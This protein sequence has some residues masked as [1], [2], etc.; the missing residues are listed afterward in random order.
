MKR[1]RDEDAS[2]LQ[3]NHTVV[4]EVKTAVVRRDRHTPRPAP[5][6]VGREI[7]VV[8]AG[9]QAVGVDVLDRLADNAQKPPVLQT[10]EIRPG[11]LLELVKRL[12]GPPAVGAQVV[13]ALDAAQ[14]AAVPMGDQPRPA[15]PLAFWRDIGAVGGGPSDKCRQNARKKDKILDHSILLL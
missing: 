6:L 14:D 8:V 4:H 9:L 5:A 12:P 11:A 15:R 7:G 13:P 2:G 1:K 10:Q 3:A